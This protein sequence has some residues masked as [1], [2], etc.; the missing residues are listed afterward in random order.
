MTRHLK[1]AFLRWNE[2]DGNDLAAFHSNF[3]QSSGGDVG[4][5]LLPVYQNL[6]DVLEI[7]V[8]HDVFP[9]SLRAFR[10]HRWRGVDHEHM[11]KSPLVLKHHINCFTGLQRY[12]VRGEPAWILRHGDGDPVPGPE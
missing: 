5:V 2:R 6:S 7:C 1:R 10:R 3:E 9:P 11:S 12:D 8:N 4:F